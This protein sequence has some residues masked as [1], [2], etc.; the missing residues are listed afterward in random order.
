VISGLP[1]GE[2]LLVAEPE[3]MEGEWESREYLKRASSRATRAT[4]SRGESITVDLT[5]SP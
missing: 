3:L 2:Y 1:Q 4:L 5:V